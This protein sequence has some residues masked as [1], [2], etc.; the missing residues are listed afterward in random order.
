MNQVLPDDL[1]WEGEADADAG[2]D[3]GAMHLSELALTAIADG[4]E[5]ILPAA[6]RAHVDACEACGRKLG[7][8]AMLSSAIGAALR[9]AATAPFTATVTATA[10]VAVKAVDSNRPRA[11]LPIGAISAG[12]ALALFGAIPMLLDL[13]SFV[14]DARFF[15][16]R[17]IPVVLRGGVSVARSGVFDRTASTLTIASAVVL[18]VASFLLLRR[19]SPRRIV[20][21]GVS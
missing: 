11:R 15:A 20:T 4:E 7:E 17:G 2:A 8:A 3:A 6:A 5:A 12:L 14:A 18:V 13:P 21:E 16:L 1:V 10:T 9:G 19:Y